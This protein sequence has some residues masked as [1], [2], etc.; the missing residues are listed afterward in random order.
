MLEQHSETNPSLRFARYCGPATDMDQAKPGW[1]EPVEAGKLLHGTT[2]V[3]SALVVE[4][5]PRIAERLVELVTVPGRLEVVASAAAE[6]EALVACETYDID[7]AIV[8]L[9]L[10]T[11]TGFGVIRRLRSPG[12]RRRPRII[13]LTNHA[14]P[15]L[16]VAAF[17]AGADYFLDKS[18]DFGALPQLIQEL[19]VES[20]D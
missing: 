13:V 7:L 18:K 16:R 10:A 3:M 6:H 12:L 11:G 20:G 4:D 9:Q 15:A 5:S 17:E 1:R 2:R 19:L 14:V 8:D